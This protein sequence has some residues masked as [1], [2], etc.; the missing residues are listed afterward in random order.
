MRIPTPQFLHP[1]YGVVL[2]ATLKEMF[3]IRQTWFVRVYVRKVP[4][5]S[6]MELLLSL[7]NI[8]GPTPL[9]SHTINNIVRLAHDVYFYVEHGR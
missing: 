8:L 2:D 9:T 3:D 6:R 1:C 5:L 4:S 7:A